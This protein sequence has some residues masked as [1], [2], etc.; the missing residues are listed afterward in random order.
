METNTTA[1]KTILWMLCHYP[2]RAEAT[3]RASEVKKI[4]D[5]CDF[6]VWLFGNYLAAWGGHIEDFMKVD[7]V[8]AGVSEDQI[9]LS[10]ELGQYSSLDTASEFVNVT[11]EARKQG[12]GNI[13]CV[14]NQL[15]L[16]QVQGMA[17]KHPD[18]NFFYHPSRLKEWTPQYLSARL[19]LI[20]LSHLGVGEDFMPLKA[21]RYARNRLNYFRL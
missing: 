2:H 12:I 9:C 14:S 10:K 8:K 6:P 3:E 13:L 17:K 19:S 7:L 21:L 5:H 15:Q 20:P 18:L 11:Q 16:W 4:T 1:P